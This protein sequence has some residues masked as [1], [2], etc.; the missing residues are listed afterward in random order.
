MSV[1]Q[2]RRMFQAEILSNCIIPP[3][4]LVVLVVIF[5]QFHKMLLSISSPQYQPTFKLGGQF[6]T[7]LKLLEI[8]LLGNL[9]RNFDWF[10]PAAGQNHDKIMIIGVRGSRAYSYHQRNWFGRGIVVIIR[11]FQKNYSS[12]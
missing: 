5:F 7:F 6:F 1:E 3:T 9:K 4:I 11:S 10:H 8:L 2:I 12:A